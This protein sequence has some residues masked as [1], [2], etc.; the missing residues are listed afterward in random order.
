MDAWVMLIIGI[1]FF[2][3]ILGYISKAAKRRKR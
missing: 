2:F 1:I 3:A